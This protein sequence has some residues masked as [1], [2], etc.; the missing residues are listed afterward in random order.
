[1]NL[2]LI[3][4]ELKRASPSHFEE[5]GRGEVPPVQPVRHDE[6]REDLVIKITQGESSI[7]R[8]KGNRL[9]IIQRKSYVG[10]KG[11]ERSAFGTRA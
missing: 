6:E 9:L 8:K 5:E 10:K 1:V 11:K 2:H 7:W 4:S 3:P